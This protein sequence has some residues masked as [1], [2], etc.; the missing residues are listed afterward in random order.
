M[1][2]IT[3]AISSKTQTLKTNESL[4]SSVL[5]HMAKIDD[6]DTQGT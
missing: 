4:V 6:W 5:G 3:K 2:Q 1:Y